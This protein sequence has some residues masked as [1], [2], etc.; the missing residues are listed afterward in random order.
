MN[1]VTCNRR[2]GW[3]SESDSGDN[4]SYYLYLSF[5]YRMMSPNYY[6]SDDKSGMINLYSNGYLNSSGVYYVSG[7]Q[8][9]ELCCL[10]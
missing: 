10:E 1:Y 6:S 7:V 2:R 8:F 9:I 5:W 3:L 4:I